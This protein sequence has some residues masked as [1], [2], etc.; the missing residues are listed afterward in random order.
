MARKKRY[1]GHFC[2]VCGE[3][4]PNEKFT[5]KGHAAH[6]CKMCAGKPLEGQ[7]E[8]IVLTRIGGVYRY[9]NLSRQN[10]L[11]LEKYTRNKSETIRQAAADALAR[12]SGSIPMPI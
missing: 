8:E 4:L 9:P 12:F 5:G 10:R 6:I 2:K 11:M 1:R 7:Q 3:V